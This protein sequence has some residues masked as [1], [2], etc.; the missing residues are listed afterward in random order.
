MIVKTFKTYVVKHVKMFIII[1]SKKFTNTSGT[2]T[3]LFVCL[4]MHGWRAGR[5]KRWKSVGKAGKSYGARG[6]GAALQSVK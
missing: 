1:K 4:M 2:C 6:R 3:S 5:G